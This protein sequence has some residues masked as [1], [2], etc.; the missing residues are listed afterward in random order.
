MNSLKTYIRKVEN[1]W[2][3][4][5]LP[6][7]QKLFNAIL[8]GAMSATFFSFLVTLLSG[9]G[10][11][12][13]LFILL[14]D[15]SMLIVF[16]LANATKLHDF[17]PAIMCTVSCIFFPVIYF[18]GGG[19]DSGMVHWFVMGIL[20]TF[21][22]LD[23]KMFFHVLNL[24]FIVYF[25]TFLLS[26][27]H[28]E[29]VMQLS[30][31][32]TRYI[33]V[34]QCAT[35]VSV[36]IGCIMKYQT[37]LYRK[38]KEINEKQKILL[39]QAMKDANTANEAKSRF[40]ANMSHEIRTPMN[41]ING[42][43]QILQ[44]K[45]LSQEDNEYV[46]IIKDSADNLL[47]IINDLLDF[48]KI[49]A[50]KFEIV[51]EEYDFVQMLD[52]I[53][54][55]IRFQLRKKDVELIV[56]ANSKVPS[57][58]Y[59]DSG[60]I[61]QILLNILNNAVKFTD[62]GSITVIIDWV[63]EDDEYG[64]FEIQIIDTGM[65][66]KKENLNALFEAFTQV[67]L[68]KNHN[69][70]GTGLGLAICKQLLS[71]MN[72]RIT[73]ESEYGK[74]T[75]FFVTFPQKIVDATPCS[76]D[77]NVVAGA[78]SGYPIAFRA[79]GTKVL[80]VDDNL[81]NLKVA[82]GILEQFEVQ[83]DTVSCGAYAIKKVQDTEYDL[84]FMDHMMPDMDGVETTARIRALE[85]QGVIPRQKI[86]ALTANTIQGVK[87]V[88][89][90]ADMDDYLP[91]PIQFAEMEE[92]LKRWLDEKHVHTKDSQNQLDERDK[93]QANGQPEGQLENSPQAQRQE[94]AKKQVVPETEPSDFLTELET[95]GL[96]TETGLDYFGGSQEMYRMVLDSF[97]SLNSRDKIQ[98]ALNRR[99]LKEYTILVH[100]VKSGAKSIGAAEFSALAFELE[101]A[102][103]AENVELIERKHPQLMQMYDELMER[104]REIVPQENAATQESTE[105]IE[106]LPELN[107]LLVKI[108]RDL[109]SCVSTR[110][111]NDLEKLKSMISVESLLWKE[112]QELESHIENFDYEEAS[113]SV[114][115][116]QALI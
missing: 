6:I 45:N 1:K 111:E 78:A 68:K 100:G 74:G 92:V 60:R 21:L 12:S 38:E 22:L 46:H 18:V 52:N 7:K 56:K 84:I 3:P 83:C 17:G 31:T 4:E 87:K 106:D 40:L 82:E 102:G 108:D 36:A 76:Y 34:A 69:K 19:I 20:F 23:G 70:Q 61:R 25:V 72:G 29:L 24:Q 58:L 8:L 54:K 90:D 79:P 62:H 28:P 101:N 35:I 16:R 116:I 115:R 44:E 55:L 97:V 57:R 63:E 77:E 59:G 27:L 50:G 88:F 64:S 48:S 15:I 5:S 37:R 104:I 49:E 81:V 89:Q 103:D 110:I 11:L 96:D 13:A 51:D 42:I 26:Y 95:I 80:V 53:V 10:L 43:A 14:G 85:K 113:A 33:D 93:Q 71:I 98:E 112:F 86:I 73:V 109:Q 65:G 47:D 2:L 94:Q 30:S 9:A 91:K 99:D 39:E 107:Q 66:I 32:H 41:A 105:Q 67:D 75:M 114:S